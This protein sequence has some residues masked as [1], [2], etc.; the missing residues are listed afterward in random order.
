LNACAGR[1]A[2]T[3]QE[4]CLERRIFFGEGSLRKGKESPVALRAA[5]SYIS[6][7]EIRIA[8]VSCM[9]RVREAEPGRKLE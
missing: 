9:A 6:N 4:S 3:I 2:G 8:P 7:Q 5:L 1:F